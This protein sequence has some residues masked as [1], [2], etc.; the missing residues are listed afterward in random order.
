MEKQAPHYI[1]YL[2]LSTFYL[3]LCSNQGRVGRS[4]R[5]S[6]RVRVLDKGRGYARGSHPELGT[7]RGAAKLATYTTLFEHVREG[8]I[9]DR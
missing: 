8:R 7:S 4:S 6:V 3:M 1:G 2:P 5:P 9:Q